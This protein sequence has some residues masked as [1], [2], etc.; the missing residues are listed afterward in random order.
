[1]GITTTVY[2]VVLV[3]CLFILIVFFVFSVVARRKRLEPLVT[4]F[5]QP[6]LGVLLL[7]L[8]MLRIVSE[9]F[10]FLIKDKFE[11]N[12]I[13]NYKKTQMVTRSANFCFE[14]RALRVVRKEMIN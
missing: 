11:M 8:K 13:Y 7:I 10:G 2:W 5:F 4:I 9:N 12:N 3:A 1:M 14:R 6:E